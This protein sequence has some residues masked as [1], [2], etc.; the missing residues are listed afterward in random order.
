MNSIEF[1]RN[2]FGLR[3][4]RGLSIEDLAAA[5]GA[6]PELICEWECAKT[7]PS[8][9]MMM[10]LSELYGV[11][12]DELIRNPKPHTPVIPPPPIWQEE[13][14]EEPTPEPEAKMEPEEPEGSAK[15][16]RHAEEP[17]GKP[18]IWEILIIV[19]FLVIIG[20]AVFFLFRPDLFPLPAFKTSAFL[21]L[22]AISMKGI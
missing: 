6:T 5:L 14:I 13:P 18:H 15:H 9:D 17:R 19:L 21:T 12:L 22:P 1:A 11:P 10:R 3:T 20:V 8:L 4:E 7:S 2:L 16:G